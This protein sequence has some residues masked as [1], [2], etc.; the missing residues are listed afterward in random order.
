MAPVLASIATILPNKLQPNTTPFAPL[1]AAS[2][3][4]P[5]GSG[6]VQRTAPELRFNA[7][8][9]PETV[10]VWFF[11]VHGLPVPGLSAVPLF[12]TATKMR[13]PSVAEPHCK[14]P[15]I[16]LAGASHAGKVSSARA[17]GSTRLR[18]LWA[19]SGRSDGLSAPQDRAGAG[20]AAI[21][22][23]KRDTPC[24]FHEDGGTGSRAAP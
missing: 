16:P 6:V 4:L 2:E 7:A 1:T 17:S 23:P 20:V 12:A 11:R 9:P 19:L 18:G 14:P 8:H 5:S 22:A 10:V 3:R 24:A 15:V 21:A 13:L